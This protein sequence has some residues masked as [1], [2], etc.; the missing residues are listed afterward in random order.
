MSGGESGVLIG[1]VCHNPAQMMETAWS[2]VFDA[3]PALAAES[4]EQLMRKIEAE[5]LLVLAGHFPF[6]GVGRLMR[7]DGRRSWVVD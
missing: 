1:D 2:P 6:P 5:R 7:V 4:R 3:N